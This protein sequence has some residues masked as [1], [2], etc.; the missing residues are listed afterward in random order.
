MYYALLIWV[1]LISGFSRIKLFKTLSFLI[2]IVSLCVFASMRSPE[3]DRDYLNY[4]YLWFLGEGDV[5]Y[6][7]EP[8][9]SAI[10]LG[11]NELGV[12]FHW[13]LFLFV[14]ISIFLKLYV[15]KKDNL[16][17]VVFLC[18]YVSYFYFQHD[19]TQIRVAAALG[20]SYLSFFYF[21]HNKLRAILYLIIGAFFHT[22]ALLLVVF[23][24]IKFNKKSLLIFSSITT[25]FFIVELLGFDVVDVIRLA[26][27]SIPFLNKYLFYFQG[28]WVQQDINVYSFTNLMFLF[29]T[30]VSTLV[31]FKVKS[32]D[33]RFIGSII[34]VYIGL[35]SIPAFSSVPVISFRLSQVYLIFI[36]YMLSFGIRY[37]PPVVKMYYRIVI[38]I[39]GLG[40]TYVIVDKAMI[41][42][43][44]KT[45]LEYSVY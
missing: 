8:L 35:C 15:V 43:D 32:P 23:F 14:F 19:M 28:E 9:S 16:D 42:K 5:N 4:Y 33:K 34:I 6:L 39:I 20:F 44:Y 25:L 38:L 45:I 27:S 29:V 7:T 13:V 24:F 41:L 3:V 40:L 11:F 26:V 30:Y 36:P 1:S 18:M 10:F 17:M 37:F 22:S 21:F 2:V 31:V 12:D